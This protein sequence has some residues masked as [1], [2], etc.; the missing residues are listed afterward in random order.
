M[1]MGTSFGICNNVGKTAPMAFGW[2]EKPTAKH[3]NLVSKPKKYIFL[4]RSN[5]DA[6]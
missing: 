1:F 4:P 6:S 3:H 2:L 5:I